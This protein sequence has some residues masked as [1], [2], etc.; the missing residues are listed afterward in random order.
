MLASEALLPS[1]FHKIRSYAQGKLHDDI[2][3]VCLDIE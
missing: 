3:L 1:I 2:A